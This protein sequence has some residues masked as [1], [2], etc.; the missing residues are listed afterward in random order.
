HRVRPLIEFGQ[1]ILAELLKRQALGLERTHLGLGRVEL[2]ERPFA[3]GQLVGRA[4]LAP[5]GLFS[6]G[7]LLVYFFAR[8]FDLPNETP[9][10]LFYFTQPR[11]ACR[12]EY[13]PRAAGPIRRLSG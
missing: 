2:D 4:A 13:R 10:G 6:L 3:L 9:S 12:H 5:P 7:H 11:R 1:P 8:S